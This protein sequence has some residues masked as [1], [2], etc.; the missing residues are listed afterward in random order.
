MYHTNDDPRAIR[1]SQM[2]YD[3][4]AMLMRERDF[5]SISVTDVAAAAQVGR[6]TFY[7][8]FDAIE[9]VLRLRCDQVFDGLVAYFLEHRQKHG[10]EPRSRLLKP[11]LRYF[12]QHSDIIE[13]LMMA[14][15]LDIVDASFSRVFVPFRAQF[16]ERFD[17]VEEEYVN[18][19][20]A[21]RI[22]VITSILVHW[23]ETGKKQTP[24]VLAEKLGTMIENMVIRDQLL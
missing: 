9:D 17:V 24:D 2:L 13:L 20:L 12:D 8:N 16:A 3:G 18:Y 7:R 23:I 11:L 6:A 22:N 10:N 4:L 1:S 14:N 21:I 5:E 19:G 15:R